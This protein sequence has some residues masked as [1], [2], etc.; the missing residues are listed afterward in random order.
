MFLLNRMLVT[1]QWCLQSAVFDTALRVHGKVAL[2]CKG[3]LL[4]MLRLLLFQEQPG[5]GCCVFM[6][7][8][9]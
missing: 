2:P 9:S 3:P 8:L 5:F 4:H 1:S 6:L 7:P